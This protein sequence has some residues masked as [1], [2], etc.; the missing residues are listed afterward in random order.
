MLVWVHAIDI[1]ITVTCTVDDPCKQS[2]QTHSYSHIHVLDAVNVIQHLLSGT[3]FLEQYSKGP[4]L[5]EFKSSQ[6]E[7]SQFISQLCKIQYKLKEN[8]NMI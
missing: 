8:I 4:S 1:P 5:T 2:P 7:S 6:V 3:H